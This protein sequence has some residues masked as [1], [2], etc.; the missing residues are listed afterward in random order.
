MVDT[1]KPPETSECDKRIFEPDRPLGV[2][3]TAYPGMVHAFRPAHCTA[4]V[5]AG[6]RTKGSSCL[7]TCGNGART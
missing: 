7:L 1:G 3:L 5:T 6:V 2:A 4:S